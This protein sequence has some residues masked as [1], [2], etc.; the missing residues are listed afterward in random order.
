MV[1]E[2]ALLN[3]IT[4]SVDQADRDA[5]MDMYRSLFGQKALSSL[6]RRHGV[7]QQLALFA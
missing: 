3:M 7:G 1:A 5:G 2:P 6:L 4:L